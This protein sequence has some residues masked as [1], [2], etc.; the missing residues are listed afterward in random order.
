MSSFLLSIL[1][2]P[3]FLCWNTIP[4]PIIIRS[5]GA[6]AREIRYFHRGSTHV[7]ENSEVISYACQ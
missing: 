1:E 6:Y 5:L 2:R 3:A 7:L 4:G